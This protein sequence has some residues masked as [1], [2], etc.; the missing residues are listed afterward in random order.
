MK[1]QFSN[2]LSQ[3][4]MDMFKKIERNQRKTE[5]RIKSE[6]ETREKL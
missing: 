4:R 3:D 2:K 1:S 5:T 6:I